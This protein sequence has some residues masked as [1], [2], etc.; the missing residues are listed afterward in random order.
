MSYL[1]DALR[2]AE[3]E[4]KLGRVPDLAADTGEAAGNGGGPS[5]TS[6]AVAVALAVGL[7]AAALGWFG[8][9]WNASPPA[10]DSAP[11]VVDA[12]P[13]AAPGNGEIAPAP[14]ERPEADV[15][16]PAPAEPAATVSAEP[17][18]PAPEP[19]P[20]P[21]PDSLPPPDSR[22]MPEWKVSGHLYS[23]IPGRSFLLIDGRRYHEGSPLPG[24]GRI[25]S[26][27]TG[28]AV[29]DYQGRRVRLAAPY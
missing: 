5:Q 24:G 22:S 8:W 19:A 11:A 9:R 7:N 17:A 25:E 18:A 1:L 28:G 12:S 16:K 20:S 21:P 2:K 27:D 26:I 4:R 23:S 3:R 14:A 13:A 6:I 29:V 15:A 10:G